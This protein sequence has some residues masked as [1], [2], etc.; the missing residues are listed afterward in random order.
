MSEPSIYIITG[1]NRGFG[2]AVANA[3]AQS[4]TLTSGSV[5]LI[6]VGRNTTALEKVATTLSQPHI[7]T[8]VV[9][10]VDFGQLDALDQNLDRLQAIIESILQKHS[11]LNR[12]VLV[13][14]AA[15][16]GD[17]SRTVREQDWHQAKSYF[18]INLISYLAIT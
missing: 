1:A 18:D 16:L 3:I 9:G 17:V 7:Q 14:N 12:A 10:E 6:L 5:H 4:T 11:I 8:H 15:T 13:N 2:Y